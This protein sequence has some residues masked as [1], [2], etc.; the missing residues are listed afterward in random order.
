MKEDTTPPLN[1]FYLKIKML[2]LWVHKRIY[3]EKQ[4]SRTN[5][6]MKK[7]LILLTFIFST[8]ASAQY[9]LTTEENWDKLMYAVAS[10]DAAE[11]EKLVKDEGYDINKLYNGR[12]TPFM[13]ACE[14]GSLESVLMILSF[15]EPYKADLRLFDPASGQTGLMLA[16]WKGHKEIVD[17][18]LKKN[19]IEKNVTDFCDK[20]AIDYTSDPEMI[21]L[22]NSYEL[23]NYY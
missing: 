4:K 14:K 13:Y 6:E 19:P 16:V 22:L 20:K 10:N 12:Y 8:S 2:A 5:K 15:E 9:Y 3:S 18:I 17:A 23:T 21:K 7:I 11:I 1:N